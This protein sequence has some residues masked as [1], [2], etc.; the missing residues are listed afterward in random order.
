MSAIKRI[1]SIREFGIFKCFEWKDSM[2]RGGQEVLFK[3][4]NFFFGRNYSGKTTLSKVFQAFE[5][6]ELPESYNNVSFEIEFD[7][8]SVL[9]QT[10]LD[11]APVPICVFN[12][13]FVTDRLGFLLDTRTG[14]PHLKAFAVLGKGSA[15]LEVQIKE[16]LDRLGNNGKD[17]KPLTGIYKEFDDV[18]KEEQEKLKA[19]KKEENAIDKICR[20]IAS[21]PGIGV[22]H[23]GMFRDP[24]YDKNDAKMDI[25]KVMAAGFVDLDED[26]YSQLMRFLKEERRPAISLPKRPI[27]KLSQLIADAKSL[28]RKEVVEGKKIHELINQAMREDW[29]RTG[30]ALHE[31]IG[32]H[33]C[34]FCGQTIP[35]QRWEDLIAHFN[36]ESERLR[37]DIKKLIAQIE[38]DESEQMMALSLDISRL[39][40]NFHEQYVQLESKRDG[41]LARYNAVKKEIKKLLD[42]RYEKPGT[43]YIGD[44]PLDVSGEVYSIYDELVALINS[45]NDYTKKIENDQNE[46]REKIRFHYILKLATNQSYSLH[47][48][49]LEDN[50]EVYR[51]CKVR[52]D[53]KKTEGQELVEEIMKLRKQRKDESAA[54][55][56]INQYMSW[57]GDDRAAIQLVPLEIEEDGVKSKVFKMERG[58]GKPAHN[59]SE[60]ECNLVAF[61]YFL[62]SL[63]APEFVHKKP[64]VWIDDPISSLDSNHIYFVY[65]MIRNAIMAENRF[66]QLFIS[67]HNLEFL[68]LMHRLKCWNPAT[69]NEYDR[70]WIMIFRNGNKS[71]IV[72]M[73]TYLKNYV[74]EFAHLFSRICKAAKAEETDDDYMEAFYE[75]GNS[76]RRFMELYLYYRYPNSNENTGLE[77]AKRVRE[78]FGDRVKAFMTERLL[79]ESSH[80]SGGMERGMKMPDTSEMKQIARC[81]LQ[82]IQFHDPKQYKEMLRGVKEKD[83]L[84]K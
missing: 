76:A 62:A 26:Q 36:D 48:K 81:I 6:K 71:N 42:R 33:K 22:K 79:N 63:S 82:S 11:K 40:C 18:K 66:S 24:N 83:P 47:V 16:K 39:Y 21:E 32:D 75:F 13:D 38:T 69:K 84:K 23:R 74:T 12:R 7:D 50:R 2:T 64:I 60:G 70:E 35:G 61:C 27:L 51:E 53:L 55:V 56:L 57:L 44:M 20:Y 67:T 14:N 1:K 3:P 59:L 28:L 72:P 49:Q 77:H 5:R 37:S 54:A 29:V 30:V 78:V 25:D 9:D 80:L 34:I 45:A 68:R 15:S 58:D 52:Y 73:P 19:V 17:G 65:A 10:K 31:T 43:P 8:N 46:A 4:I 41:I